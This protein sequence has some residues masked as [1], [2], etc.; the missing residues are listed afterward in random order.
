MND[1][2]FE[3]GDGAGIE[4]ERALAFQGKDEAEFVLFDLPGGS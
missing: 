4:E 3:P 1:V 2:P